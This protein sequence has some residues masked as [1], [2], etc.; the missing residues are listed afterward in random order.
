MKKYH[1]Y[2]IF[3]GILIMYVL[4]INSFAMI[5]AQTFDEASLS[6]GN[7]A[8]AAMD[9]KVGVSDSVSVTVVRNRFYGT[10]VENA[11]SEGIV[12]YV[13]LFNL[14]KLPLIVKGFHF[15]YLHLI[16]VLFSIGL[17]VFLTRIEKRYDSLIYAKDL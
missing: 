17:F 8:G 13:Y 11:G 3:A 9:V 5:L 4:I 10:I 15:G 6:E 7:T 12:S 1:K 2:L 16:M 14:L